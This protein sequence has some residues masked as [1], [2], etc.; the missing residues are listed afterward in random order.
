MLFDL[1][2]GGRRRGVQATYLFLAVLIGG[3]LVLFGI[4]GSGLG[5]GLVDAITN[6]GGGTTGN[7]AYE[8]R[9]QQ[10]TTQTRA[11]PKDAAAWAALARA[12]YQLASAPENFNSST[13]TW[14]ASGK[15]QL[16]M[17][18]QAWQRH[19]AVAGKRP[20]DGVASLMVNVYSAAGLNRPADAVSA[21]EIITQARPTSATFA[22]LAV[23]AYQAGQ[24]RKGD[25]AARKALSLTDK[26]LRTNLKSQLDAAKQQALSQAAGPGAS[27]AP[28]ATPGAAATP[29]AGTG[30][31]SSNGAKSGSGK[32]SGGK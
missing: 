8:K 3:G 4:G 2:G 20:D 5:G 19:L 6:G 7:A 13:G 29:T 9:V 22:R 31:G 27:A 30:S 23:L 15:R 10:A 16:Q 32:G 12:R 25:L 24:T 17:A 1:R 18:S 28:T 11:N 14:N 21:Q 26:D